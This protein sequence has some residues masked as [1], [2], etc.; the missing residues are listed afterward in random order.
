MCIRHINKSYNSRLWFSEEQLRI[1]L[2][3]INYDITE[4]KGRTQFMEKFI[5]VLTSCMPVW[6]GVSLEL[7]DVNISYTGSY[8][9]I[10]FHSYSGLLFFAEH[11][12]MQHSA[13]QSSASFLQ[14]SY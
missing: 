1:C 11:E 7:I 3:I 5:K 13:K 12:R 6:D 8:S 14:L 9:V 10:F 4:R 2:S